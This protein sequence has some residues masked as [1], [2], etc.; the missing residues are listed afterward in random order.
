MH[1]GFISVLFFVLTRLVSDVFARSPDQA[2]DV[3]SAEDIYQPFWAVEL[4]QRQVS[5]ITS[6]PNSAQYSQAQTTTS[7][8]INLTPFGGTPIPWVPSESLNPVPVTTSNTAG[9]PP[10]TGYPACVNLCLAHAAH[11][12]NCTSVIAVEC[13]LTL[14]REKPHISTGA[15]QLYRPILY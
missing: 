1:Q 10:L 12:A 15:R 4:K 9:I 2:T 3:Y 6:T 13:Y 11:A 14:A 7:V 5:S 8:T